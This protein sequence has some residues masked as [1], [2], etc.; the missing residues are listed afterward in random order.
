[1]P[2]HR[3]GVFFKEFPIYLYEEVYKKLSESISASM[4]APA[5]ATQTDA[6]IKAY[7]PCLVAIFSALTSGKP[8][9]A[10]HGVTK[11]VFGYNAQ[12][13]ATNLTLTMAFLGAPPF[14]TPL[15]GELAC[16][17]GEVGAAAWVG[18]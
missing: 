17:F 7:G 15:P 10:F 3:S 8:L 14:N 4:A 6:L 1:M 5:A 16:V 18:W 9:A 11:N 12:V 2:A 13:P